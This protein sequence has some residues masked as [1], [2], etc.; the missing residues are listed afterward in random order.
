MHLTRTG[1]EIVFTRP[2]EAASATAPESWK[3]TRYDYDY[4]EAYGSKQHDLEPVPVASVK[5]SPDRQR[6]TIEFA[7]LTPW[8]VYEFHLDALKADDGAAIANPLVCYTLNHL[9][10][11]TPPP[12]APGREKGGNK[13][14]G[15]E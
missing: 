14:G 12:P 5:L 3:I 2:I 7:T 10:E 8:R 4:H 13:N 15:A 1:F 6:A 9:L 11:N